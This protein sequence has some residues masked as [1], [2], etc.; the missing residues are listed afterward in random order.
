[1]HPFQGH[2][3][4]TVGAVAEPCI[5]TGESPW[6]ENHVSACFELGIWSLNHYAE[7]GIVEAPDALAAE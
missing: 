6:Q 1:M 5:L 3:N 4:G 2:C 7:L